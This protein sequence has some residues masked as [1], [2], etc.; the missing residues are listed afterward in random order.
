MI[1]QILF[2]R[3]KKKKNI[4]SL[5]SAE[6]D[7]RVVMVKFKVLTLGALTCGDSSPSEK[8]QNQKGCHRLCYI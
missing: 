6:L 8:V 7:S 4:I 1:C 2:S 3:G 5:S